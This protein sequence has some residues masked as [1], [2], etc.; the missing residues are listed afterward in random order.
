MKHYS[1]RVLEPFNTETQSLNPAVNMRNSIFLAGPCP[2]NNYEEDWRYGVFDMLEELGFTGT[3]ITPTNDK[4]SE[5]ERHEAEA[6]WAQTEWE[7]TMMHM[8][9]ALVFWVPRSEKWPAFTTNIE[10]GEWYKKK[11]VYFGFPDDAIRMT[12]LTQKFKEQKKSWYNDLRTM[13]ADVVRDLQASKQRKWFTSDTHFG[14]QRTL[15]LSCRPFVD[16][17]EM[18]LTMISN[19]NKSVRPNDIVYHAGDFVDYTDLSLL[20][21]LLGNLNFKKLHWVLGNYDRKYKDKIAAIVADFN[22]VYATEREI[23]IYDQTDENDMCW[24]GLQ[25]SEGNWHEYV[26]VHEPVDFP[27]PKRE[28]AVY[29]Y[30]HIHGRSFAKTN[31][32]D[33]G[34]D[35]HHYAPVSEE[36]VLWFTNAMKYWDKNVYCS[37]VETR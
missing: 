28:N 16:L 26:I 32:F 20:Q 23:E 19:W 33:L 30:G 5:M 3:V 7:R 21:D 4:Y 25:D 12:Y 10:F 9:S 36:Q 14:Q 24:T 35:Y 1:F 11:G 31:G 6:H 22:Q 15:E 8:C 17:V 13:L 18:D 37:K 29:L 27:A 2:R 34:T